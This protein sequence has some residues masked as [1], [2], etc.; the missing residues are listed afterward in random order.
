MAQT[1]FHSHLT[2]RWAAFFD[3]IG[4]Q[5]THQPYWLDGPMI[6][7][8]AFEIHGDHPLYVVVAPPKRTTVK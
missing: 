1:E 2:A 5:H 3:R 8:S 6:I 7:A 4:W